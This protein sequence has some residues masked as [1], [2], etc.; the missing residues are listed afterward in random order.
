MILKNIGFI[1]FTNNTSL[2][3]EKKKSK[4]FNLIY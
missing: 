3:L 1:R 4:L 2:I